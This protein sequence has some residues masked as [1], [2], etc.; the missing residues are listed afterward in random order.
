MIE[1]PGLKLGLIGSSVSRSLSPCIHQ[2]FFDST[3]IAGSYRLFDIAE[4]DLASSIALMK[5]GPDAM[6]GINVTIPHK[7]GVIDFLSSCSP[8]ARAAGAVNTIAFK[9][10]KLEGHNTDILGLKASLEE[11]LADRPLEKV[12]EKVVIVGTGGAARAAVIA[13]A[14]MGASQ[15]Q[16]LARNKERAASFV[17]NIEQSLRQCEIILPQ[18]AF[19]TF[20]LDEEKNFAGAVG[21]CQIIINATSVGHLNNEVPSWL[22]PLFASLPKD[23][24]VQD[25]VYAKSSEPTVFCRLA[26]EFQFANNDGKA[27]L[28]HQARFAFALFAG[29]LPSYEVGIKAL[30]AA[31]NRA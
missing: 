6:D 31:S 23:V 19:A 17:A 22:R 29:Q 1:K 3:G 21:S 4:S 18:L 16:I 12:I 27:M 15:F 25:L 26:L 28:V 2:A 24:F 13:L 11:S 9:D 10:Q 14:E 20:G 7:V 8:Q 5:D 30:L